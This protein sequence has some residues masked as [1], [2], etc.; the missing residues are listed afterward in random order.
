MRNFTDYLDKINSDVFEV[1]R[2]PHKMKDYAF[3]EIGN[4]ER[5]E[6]ILKAWKY[7]M[8][9]KLNAVNPKTYSSFFIDYGYFY[10]LANYNEGLGN[11]QSG[12]LT[13][14]YE[15]M[16]Q[17]PMPFLAS[18]SMGELWIE[19]VRIP[20][21]DGVIPLPFDRCI[22]YREKME[23]LEEGYLSA[24]N[25]IVG[26]Y[27]NLVYRTASGG[28]KS[29][30][31]WFRDTYSINSE[32]QFCVYGHE[33]QDPVPTA[34]FVKVGYGF[35]YK[36]DFLPEIPESE[37]Q[38]YL[39]AYD[40][41]FEPYTEEGDY[42]VEPNKL[43]TFEECQEEKRLYE[44]FLNHSYFKSYVGKCYRENNLYRYAFI[45]EIHQDLQKGYYLEIKFLENFSKPIK[46]VDSTKLF[47][48]MY[49]EKDQDYVEDVISEN[50]KPKL[51]LNL[52]MDNVVKLVGG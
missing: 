45:P 11:R 28:V 24:L 42:I 3:N 5:L 25:G 18:N 27:K 7:H 10:T 47:L 22:G 26:N 44:S 6:V 49:S 31:S 50:M 17:R 32:W 13:G 51:M 29:L 23:H 36:G 1:Y 8:L 39:A 40:L 41:V 46:W 48:K 12:F 19:E 9:Y 43:K 35:Q 38:D 15:Y 30:F 4:V 33:L 16:L 20:E 52:K 21:L 37:L 34:K 14:C 2:T